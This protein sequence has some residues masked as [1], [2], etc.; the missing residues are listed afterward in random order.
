VQEGKLFAEYGLKLSTKDIK[1]LDSNFWNDQPPSKEVM[2]KNGS[3][4]GFVI[5]KVSKHGDNAKAATQS[6]TL[7]TSDVYTQLTKLVTTAYNTFAIIN[8]RMERDIYI[9]LYYARGWMRERPTL[10]GVMIPY[11]FMCRDPYPLNKLKSRP[12]LDVVNDLKRMLN[13]SSPF[14]SEAIEQARQK[15]RVKGWSWDDNAKVMAMA[16]EV[17]TPTHNRISYRYMKIKVAGVHVSTSTREPKASNKYM[18]VWVRS[19]SRLNQVLTEAVRNNKPISQFKSYIPNPLTDRRFLQLVVILVK[20]RRGAEAAKM[21][22]KQIQDVAREL[23]S[24]A[25]QLLDEQLQRLNQGDTQDLIP[26]LD[27]QVLESYKELSLPNPALTNAVRGSDIAVY[28]EQ[29]KQYAHFSR[30]IGSQVEYRISD[31]VAAKV[32][33][34]KAV[35]WTKEIAAANV[36]APPILPS[37]WVQPSNLPKHVLISVPTNKFV[38]DDEK[39]ALDDPLRP[40]EVRS[41]LE[42]ITALVKDGGYCGKTHEDILRATR[43]LCDSNDAKTFTV[44]AEQSNSPDEKKKATSPAPQSNVRSQNDMLEELPI[45]DL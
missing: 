37:Y 28:S 42:L 23:C 43:Q 45:G 36:G 27:T 20:C 41:F 3:K 38:S 40:A 21:T 11:E 34:V 13:A 31:D 26:E 8:K 22:S 30:Y 7:L 1:P 15:V 19:D 2:E 25:V 24:S 39:P 4:R 35:R 18:E 17:G 32:G 6:S 44:G 9:L 12:Y 33:I 14:H 10:K 5:Y 29:F 16:K